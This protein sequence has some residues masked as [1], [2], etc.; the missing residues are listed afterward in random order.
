MASA[1]GQQ[2]KMLQRPT[3]QTTVE[4]KTLYVLFVTAFNLTV[5]GVADLAM[6]LSKVKEIILVKISVIKCRSKWSEKNEKYFKYFYLRVD[7][8]RILFLNI[9]IL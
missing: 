4:G 8:T 7:P 5:P 9:G 1:A 3:Q 2:P 6:D